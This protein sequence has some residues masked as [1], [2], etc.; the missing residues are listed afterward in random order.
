MQPVVGVIVVSITIELGYQ[1]HAL[2]GITVKR[3]VLHKAK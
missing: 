1:V 2:I 3:Y